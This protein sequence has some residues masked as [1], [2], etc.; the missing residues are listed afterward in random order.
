MTHQWSELPLKD[1]RC[2]HRVVLVTFLSGPT[3]SMVK[4]N[5]PYLCSI[6]GTGRS[7]S[8]TSNK[9]VTRRVIL[10]QVGNTLFS[11]ETL[12]STAPSSASE[13]CRQVLSTCSKPTTPRCWAAKGVSAVSMLA[14]GSSSLLLSSAARQE[15]THA[16]YRL[17]RALLPAPWTVLTPPIPP[18]QSFHFCSRFCHAIVALT[19]TMC[20]TAPCWYRMRVCLPCLPA[21]A[22]TVW[23]SAASEPASLRVSP[24]TCNE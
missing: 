20:G 9:A 19:V 17:C 5:I 4:D 1:A 12:V 22:C 14:K 7:D 23:R 21:K 6:C 16:H 10:R 3:W 24:R 11:V 2:A 18:Q 8:D 15:R 13:Y